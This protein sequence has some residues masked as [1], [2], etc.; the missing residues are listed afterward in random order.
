MHGF[1]AK[2]NVLSVNGLGEF[3]F[4]VKCVD[5]AIGV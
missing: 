2:F 5:L 1:E 3:S 4:E